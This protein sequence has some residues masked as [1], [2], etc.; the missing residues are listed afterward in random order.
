LDHPPPQDR[1]EPGDGPGLMVFQEFG[2]EPEEILFREGLQG[3]E[4]GFP[5]GKFFISSGKFSGKYFRARVFVN[6]FGLF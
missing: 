1:P 3:L 4:K 6:V 5:S 2:Q